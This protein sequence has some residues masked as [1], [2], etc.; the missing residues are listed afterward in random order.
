MMQRL[1]ALLIVAFVAAPSLAWGASPE[2][3][4]QPLTENV[5]VDSFGIRRGTYAAYVRPVVPT[6]NVRASGPGSPVVGKMARDQEAQVTGSC[7]HWLEI[8][9]GFIHGWV[10]GPLTCQTN[11]NVQVSNRDQT[12][13][14]NV[15]QYCE[16]NDDDAI[17]KR[18]MRILRGE[19]PPIVHFRVR[20]DGARGHAP[21]WG[22]PDGG[23]VVARLRSGT[24]VTLVRGTGNDDGGY[25]VNLE[26][27]NPGFQL[28][29]DGVPE[30]VV[31]SAHERGVWVRVVDLE[32][33]EDE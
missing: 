32:R 23:W 1:R 31:K 33:I 22:T 25:W 27:D 4:Y 6:L 14:W 26:A 30:S 5:E 3:D 20:R 11:L 21:T 10:F 16:T 13:T 18:G 15:A 8:R 12:K 7:G 9:G 29:L 2:C 19:P 17:R 24:I 28:T